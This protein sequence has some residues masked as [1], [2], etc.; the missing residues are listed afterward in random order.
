MALDAAARNRVADPGD[1]RQHVVVV[2]SA[3]TQVTKL[4]T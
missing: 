3:D 2:V 4:N 1:G